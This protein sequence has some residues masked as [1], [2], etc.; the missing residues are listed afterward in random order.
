[1][2]MDNP[3]D[4]F[5][6]YYFYSRIL[7]EDKSKKQPLKS[8][9][10]KVAEKALEFAKDM[11]PMGA[12]D[13]HEVNQR[14]ESFYNTAHCAGLL[15]DLGKYRKEF[16]EYLFGKRGRSTET[17]HSVYGSAAAL[18][19]FK[20]EVSAFAVAGHHAGLH[21]SGVLDEQINGRKYEAN[22]K[23][24]PLLT[25]AQDEKE[26][27]QL[28]EFHSDPNIDPD[29]SDKF[30]YEF[31]TRML[32]SII[33]D[34]DRLDA[35][36][37]EMEQK[38]GKPW[39]R[40][41]AK[42]DA[43]VLLERI[44]TV[45]DQKKREH[46]DDDLNYLRNT[47][48]DACVDKGK[49][50][51]QGFFSLTVP[52]GGGKT[53]SSM[54]F[55]L[56]HAKKHCLRRVIVV[57]PYLSIIEQNAEEYRDALG[58]EMV[59]EHHSAVELSQS[60]S[61]SDNSDLDE[62]TNASDMEKAMENWDMPVIVTTSVQFIETLFAAS[63]GQARKL[64][65][66]PRSVVI[67]DEVQTLPAHLLEPTLNV[68]REFK[69]RWGVSFLF[70]SATQPAFRK[71]TAL[72]NGFEPDE[73]T[74]I[75]P[76]PENIF[77]KLRR[78]DYCIEPKENPLNWRMIAERMTS[79][80]QVLCIL[81]IR[82][83]A[84]ELWDTLRRL[85]HEKGF[86]KEEEEALFHLSSAMCPAHRLD[87]LGLSKNPAP[88]N[89][90]ER[91]RNG[92][93]CWVASTQLIEA[94]VDIDFPVVFRAMGPLDSIV[95][96]AGRCNREGLLQDEQGNLCRGKVVI[97]CPS[98]GGLPP[99]IYSK[100]TS[101]TPAYL[102]PERI[103]EDPAIFSQYFHELYQITPTDFNQ[104]GQHTIQEDRAEFRFRKVAEHARV[105]KKGETVSVIVPYG[106]GKAMIDQIRRTKDFDFKTLRRLQRYM[107]NV[108][109]QEHYS[110]FAK[111]NAIGA[112][113]PLLP[114]RLEIPVIGD[115][116][117]KTAPPLGVVIENRP[118]EDFIL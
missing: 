38:T 92:K 94:G 99:G 20:D 44:Q 93:P 79:H 39:K 98:D 83:Q 41:T 65:N 43:E 25:L 86:V 70:C 56:S 42:L 32:F 53:L 103:A 45:R 107:V 58:D 6:M 62:P 90:M 112:I 82:R 102:E 80:Q 51:P 19:H 50:L 14:K 37:W 88:N 66:I 61:R 57:I 27:G 9:L 8:H 7:R 115:W 104:R 78:V 64:H 28:L 105:I 52:T 87:L 72:K 77:K 106:K 17:D 97:F 91:L 108:R 71:S 1:M 114:D 96:A 35:E 36:Q 40:R 30:H 109:K 12:E 63:P 18:F 49:R 113:T 84:F 24:I 73:M 29:D 31:I 117:Y 48:F 55:A 60:A 33:V 101:I 100:G 22:E 67:F 13:S 23:Y 21:D 111:L 46:P 54:A 26:L 16:Q 81:N 75:V 74:P 76:E 85:L 95:Q 15:H 10:H 69:D 11:Q 59:L 68:L 2:K 5:K 34:A 47:I 110:D 4:E 3:P 118:M 89:I 116:C